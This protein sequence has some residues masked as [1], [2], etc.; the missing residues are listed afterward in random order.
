MTKPKRIDL[1]PEEL[2]ALLERVESENLQPGDFELIKGM[3]ETIAYLSHVADQKGVQ[4]ARLLR[5][6]FGSST[7]KRSAVLG[8][9]E[10]E[11]DPQAPPDPSSAS[12][13]D[14]TNNKRTG[15]GRR[16]ANE[17]TGAKT[18]EVEHAELKPGDDCPKCDGGT[19]YEQ[20]AP[21][22]VVR[23]KA[24]PP[25]E[26]CIHRLQK[27][28]CGL[29][30]MIFTA[31]PPADVGPQKYDESVG[32]LL[33]LLKYGTGMPFYRLAKLQENLGVPLPSSTQ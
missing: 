29:C 3:A 14:N 7:E 27:L 4:V 31:N 11:D 15:N 10:G 33:A 16:G 25:F 12:E 20:S 8:E 13:G 6:L 30:G 18:I 1:T 19:L 28:R 2:D 22:T 21:G 17:Y 23:V 26:A 24:S 9:P 5:T 32:S